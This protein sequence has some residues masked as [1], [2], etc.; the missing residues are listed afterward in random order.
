MIDFESVKGIL[1]DFD[2][3]LCIHPDHEESD[4]IVFR[5]KCAIGTAWSHCFVNHWA[6]SIITKYPDKKMGLISY[7]DMHMEASAKLQWVKELYNVRMDDFCVGSFDGKGEGMKLAAAL[8]KLMPGEIL[9]VDDM[10]PHQV[11]ATRL[12]F[13]TCSPIELAIYVEQ[14]ELER[15]S[16]RAEAST[17]KVHGCG[18]H[19]HCHND[20]DKE[21][22]IKYHSDAIERLCNIEGDKSDWID[23]RAAE[24]V[25]IKAGEF[26]L[27]SLGISMKLPAGYEAHVVPRSSTFKN[28]GILQTNS[29]GIIDNSYCGNNDVWKFPALAVRDTEIKVNDRICQFRIVKKQESITFREVDR[30]EDT[31][32]GGFGSTGTA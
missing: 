1:W 16:Q 28:W 11:T 14:M 3:V 21:I 2:D 12:G 32:R 20:R 30:L 24:N 4:P 8:W 7:A 27:I 15:E 25:K 31:D 13:K 26:A 5:R 19:C 23:L 6:A 22:S 18:G 29:M 10:V 17:H 9:V